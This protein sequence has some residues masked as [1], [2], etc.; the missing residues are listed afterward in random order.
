MIVDDIRT[1]KKDRAINEPIFFCPRGAR[2]PSE[3]VINRITKDKIPA[4]SV[5]PNPPHSQ[6]VL[7]RIKL[8]TAQ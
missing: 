2:Q 8:F 4:A 5:A 3:L 1:E 6:Q 7:P